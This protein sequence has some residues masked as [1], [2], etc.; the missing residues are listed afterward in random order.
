[1]FY[2]C[3]TNH[4]AIKKVNTIVQLNRIKTQDYLVGINEVERE[5]DFNNIVLDSISQEPYHPNFDSS[6]T[7]L[8]ATF[9]LSKRNYEYYRKAYTL[10][11][12]LGDIGG[13]FEGIIVINTVLLWPYYHNI[14]K[15]LIFEN[16]MEATPENGRLVLSRAFKLQWLLCDSL[17]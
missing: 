2:G 7:I 6:L 8:K 9:N 14:W 3:I 4:K 15:Y 5:K 16:L 12:A 1:M 17:K 13:L 10:L 11:E